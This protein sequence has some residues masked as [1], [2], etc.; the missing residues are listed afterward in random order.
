VNARETAA[1]EQ[2]TGNKNV[3]RNQSH[4]YLPKEILGRMIKMLDERVH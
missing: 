1:N 3:N 2:K 4:Q